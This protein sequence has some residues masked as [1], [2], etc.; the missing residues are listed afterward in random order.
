M[1]MKALL[2]FISRKEAIKYV[3]SSDR[4]YDIFFYL[5]FTIQTFLLP[6][7]PS[8][9][10]SP[11]VEGWLGFSI[12]M[13]FVFLFYPLFYLRFYKHEASDFIREIV[14]LSVVTRFN[15]FFYVGCLA[16][17]QISIWSF[18][19]F[20]KLPNVSLIYYLLYYVTFA[21]LMVSCKKNSTRTKSYLKAT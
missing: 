14:V 19:K 10:H 8:G 6:S 7:I 17:V 9:Y 18:L 2:A 16:L 20:P 3:V 21:T 5:I 13:A 15:S 11:N 1:R 12:S 4:I